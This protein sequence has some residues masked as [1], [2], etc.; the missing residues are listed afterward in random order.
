MLLGVCQPLLETLDPIALRERGDEP[1]GEHRAVPHDVRR[2]LV[3]P[4][5]DDGFSPLAQHGRDG[6]LDLSGGQLD[7]VGCKRV[8]DRCLGLVRLVEPLTGAAV[9]LGHLC[10]PLIA[11]AHVEHIGEEVVV[12]IPGA[13]CVEGD[14]EQVL[15]FQGLQHLLA[16][17]R[18]GDRIAQRGTQSVEDR[19]V[20][21]ESTHVRWLPVEDLVSEVVHDE[22][23][24][25][26]EPGDELRAVVTTLEGQRRELQG[27][28]HPSV[29]LSRAATS[30]GSSESVLRSL[31]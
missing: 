15:P 9:Q 26:G 27:A 10:G 31:R 11:Q 22:P 7:V 30:R 5:A 24:V 2:Q 17:R 21:Q 28:T 4:A 25:T 8:P 6:Q 12:P 29:R 1:D 16:A 18:P 3:D 20:Q 23:V 19:G 13:V 14:D